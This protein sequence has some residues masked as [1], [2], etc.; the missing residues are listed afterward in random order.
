MLYSLKR[1]IALGEMFAFNDNL[2]DKYL[3][4]QLTPNK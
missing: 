3:Q 4:E 2:D 1:L